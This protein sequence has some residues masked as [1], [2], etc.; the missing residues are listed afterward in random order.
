MKIGARIFGALAAVLLLY[1]VVGLLLPGEW[2]AEVEDELHHPPEEVFPLL[3]N[4]ESWRRWAALPDSGTQL[5]GPPSGTG[6][7]IRWDDPRYGSGEV[8]ITES[9]PLA[10]VGYIVEVEGGALTIHGLLTLEASAPGTRLRW[11]EEGKF[12]W[13][14]LLG[15]AARGM[16]ASQAEAMRAG[17][18]R[19]RGLLEER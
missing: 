5:F 1:L 19:L 3:D 10:S 12:G 13:N 2:V 14:P 7:G 15:Y 8:R 11:R 9:R 4:M 17:L 16:P 18:D 6:A